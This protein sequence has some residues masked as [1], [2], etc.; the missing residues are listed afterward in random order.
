MKYK[1]YLKKYDFL[2]LK[3]RKSAM[4]GEDIGE[5]VI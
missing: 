1:S 5:E 4:E 3:K 2:H